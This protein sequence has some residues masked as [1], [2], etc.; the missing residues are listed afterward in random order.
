MMTITG[1]VAYSAPEIRDHKSSYSEKVDMWS[2]GG[3]LY[4]IL[5]GIPPFNSNNAEELDEAILSGKYDKDE[6]AWD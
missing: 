5:F 4:F 2:A 6:K 1:A 3:V